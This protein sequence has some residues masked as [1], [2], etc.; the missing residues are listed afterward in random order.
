MDDSVWLLSLVMGISGFVSASMLV[1]E[2]KGLRKK[3]WSN[4][5]FWVS[6]GVVAVT[7]LSPP[8]GQELSWRYLFSF[9]LLCLAAVTVQACSPP[10]MFNED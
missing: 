5:F 1:V 3:R 4:W 6:F 10:W 2:S 7:L 9:A 8:Y